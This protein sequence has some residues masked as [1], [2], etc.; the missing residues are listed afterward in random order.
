MIFLNGK[1]ELFFDTVQMAA[2]LLGNTIASNFL[3]LCRCILETRERLAQMKTE[4][5]RMT[6]ATSGS[7]TCRKSQNIGNTRSG[8]LYGNKN[9]TGNVRVT[10]ISAPYNAV[11]MPA[12]T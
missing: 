2:S 7:R 12:A 4:N 1:E 3:A 8:L 10:D 11:L 6:T 9:K 5:Y